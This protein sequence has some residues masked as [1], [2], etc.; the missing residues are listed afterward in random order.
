F[1]ADA[2][3]QM[4]Y[5]GI[6]EAVGIVLAP[7]FSR[8]SVGDYRGY[9]EQARDMHAPKMRLEV[10]ERWGA[11]PAFIDA[12]AKRVQEALKGLYPE[13]TLVIFSAH[14]LPERAVADGDPYKQE[15]LETSRL[16]AEAAKIP[17]WTFGFQSASSTGEPWIGPDVLDVIKDQ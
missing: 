7:H 11:M 15:L 17:H 4:A 10:I 9:A 5:D 13:T 6:E 2:V 3:E 14:S 12:L 8:T 1:V 16:V